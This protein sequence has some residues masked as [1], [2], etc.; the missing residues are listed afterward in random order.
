VGLEVGNRVAGQRRE[1]VLSGLDVE[2]RGLGG[3]RAVDAQPVGNRTFLPKASTTL[4][5]APAASRGASNAAILTSPK[6]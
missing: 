6:A 5:R 1:Q 2:R 3:D 4:T